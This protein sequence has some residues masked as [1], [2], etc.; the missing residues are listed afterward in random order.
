MPSKQQLASQR[1]HQHMRN[2][3]AKCMMDPL[4]FIKTYIKIQHQ[5]RGI[6]PFALYPFQ[7]TGL[8]DFHAHSRCIVLKSRQMGISTLVAAYA[9]WELIFHEGKNV[10]VISTKETAAK[11][12]ISKITLA[13]DEL[14][15][16]LKIPVLES[17]KLSL[18]LN[19]QSRVLATS[20]ASDSA[21]GFAASL[22][23]IDECAFIDDIED[24]WTSA[25]QTLA[26]VAAG[27]AIILSTPNGMGNFFHRTWSEAEAKQNNFKT[28]KIHWSMHPDRDQAWRDAQTRELGARMAGQEC[29]CDFLASGNNVI[30][31][32]KLVEIE[33][34]FVKD[35]IDYAEGNALWIWERPMDAVD[36]L[37]TAD[38][39]TGDGS[40][41]SA[42]HVINRDTMTQVAEYQDKIGILEFARILVSVATRYNNAQLVVERESYGRG[43]LEFIIAAGYRNLIYTNSNELYVETSGKI[44]NKYYAEEKKL[45]PGFSTNEK[46]R[47]LIIGKVELYFSQKYFTPHS[48][49]LIHELKTFIWHNGRAEA[50]RGYHDDLVMSLGIG[51]WVRDNS[52]KYKEESMEVARRMIEGIHTPDKPPEHSPIYTARSAQ[53]NAFDQWNMRVGGV[54]SDKRENLSWLL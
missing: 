42:F 18:K 27:K 49:R 35:P 23:I 54:G 21:R 40:D 45:L 52:L 11:E 39:A 44:R 4:Y 5:D 12:I 34:E 31:L 33:K 51:L 16:W 14:P 32:I 3:Y 53:N 7:E 46:T 19:N 9:L 29:D 30:D 1:L 47:I 41:Y 8:K 48:I 43:V 15:P 50:A 10:L 20:S 25:Q 13:N 22:L 37:I 17:N 26:T 28:I 6:I 36:Y 24:I 38:V 2:E